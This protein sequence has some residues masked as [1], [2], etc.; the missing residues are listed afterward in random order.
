M[1]NVLF[2]NIKCGSDLEFKVGAC[3]DNVKITGKKTKELICRK[4]FPED[5]YYERPEIDVHF[6]ISEFDGWVEIYGIPASKVI[7]HP[8][9]QYKFFPEEFKKI[10]LEKSSFSHNWKRELEDFECESGVFN[11]QDEQREDINKLREMGLNI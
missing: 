5:I 11:I 1:K 9:K 6:D 8:D 4:I 7:T 3:L 10:D 2:E